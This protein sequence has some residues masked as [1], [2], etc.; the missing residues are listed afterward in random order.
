MNIRFG[1]RDINYP[2]DT[3]GTLQD[4]HHLLADVP[5]LHAQMPKTAIFFSAGL[6]TAKRCSRRGRQFCTT[7]TSRM[8]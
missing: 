3:L 4:S 8:Y 6:S 7:C 5:A 1:Y 2:G